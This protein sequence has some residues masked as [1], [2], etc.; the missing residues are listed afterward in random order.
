MLALFGESGVVEDQLA[1]TTESVADPGLEAIENDLLISGTLIEEL[2]QRLLVIFVFLF[3]S[4]ETGRNRF[5][6]FSLPIKQHTSQ[7]SITPT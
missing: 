2:L 1:F 3:D 7:V 5:D 4:L 6:A